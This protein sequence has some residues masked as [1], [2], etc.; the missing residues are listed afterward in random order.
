[1]KSRSRCRLSQCVEV[2]SLAAAFV[3]LAVPARACGPDFPNSTLAATADALLAAPEGYF[4]TEI[5]LLAGALPVPHRAIHPERNAPENRQR[6]IEDGQLLEA[7]EHSGCEPAEARKR[8]RDFETWRHALDAWWRRDGASRSST[9]PPREPDGVPAEFVLYARGATAWRHTGWTDAHA[10]WTALLA[11][12][13]A[14]RRYRTLWVAYMFGRDAG[15]EASSASTRPRAEALAE[16]QRWFRLVRDLAA[17]GAPDP[18]G[19]AAESYGWEARAALNSG[20]TAAAATLYLQQYATGDA[21]ASASLRMMTRR[22]LEPTLDADAARDPLVRRLMLAYVVSRVGSIAWDDEPQPP[23]ARWAAALATAIEATGD[24]NLAEA[25]RLAWLAYEGAQFELAGRWAQ[26]APEDAPMARWIR[27]K[28]SLRASNSAEAVRLLTLVAEDPRLDPVHGPQVH[29]ELGRVRLARGDHWGT[30]AAW[31]RGGH[32]QDAAYVA[33]RVMTLDELTSFVAS[34]S[35]PPPPA[36]SP[37]GTSAGEWPRRGYAW[38][39]DSLNAQ[40]QHLL[41]RRLA[42]AGMVEE[43]EPHF[44]EKWRATVRAYGADVRTGFNAELPAAERAAAFW[45]AAQIARE[46]GLDLLGTEL[47]PDWFIWGGQYAT[48]DMEKVRRSAAP[49]SDSAF[50]I[51]EE[52]NRRLEDHAVPTKRFH[53]RYRAAE[54]AGW[55]A[56]LLPN[57][58][59]Q[60]AEILDTAGRWLMRRDPEAAKPF[61]QLLVVR[62]PHTALGRRAAIHHWFSDPDPEPADSAAGAARTEAKRP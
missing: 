35:M 13:E 6:L 46:H 25:D 21:T 1:M 48:E 47:E 60:A 61:Y 19:L 34:A 59:E 22:L 50:A 30:L 62:C 53:Y 57:D 28:L 2:G 37:A 27:A 52:E 49:R 29:A 42:R 11:L 45:R 54:L 43:A 56:A 7:L 26:L 16:A 12:P 23:F 58:S 20:A 32:W 5:A 41:G 17:A 18:L 31:L 44:P 3:A 14:Q 10:A 33:E 8:A 9:P 4:S 38:R 55:A 15:D 39:P 40:L 36:K 51:T 24:T